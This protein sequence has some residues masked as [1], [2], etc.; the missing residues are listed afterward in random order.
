[1]AE[2]QAEEL[3]DVAAMAKARAHRAEA[4]RSR[5][6]AAMQAERAAADAAWGAQVDA[7][8]PAAKRAET[9]AAA[10][11]AQ[12]A[13]TQVV[14]STAA[15]AQ[16]YHALALS[17]RRGSGSP[18]PLRSLGFGSP[19]SRT[20]PSGPRRQRWLSEDLDAL[21]ALPA[22]PLVAV[23]GRQQQDGA[24]TGRMHVGMRRGI[25]R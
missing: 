14:V 1:M 5:L 23:V 22:R 19:P 9:A 17:Q 25:A 7:A 16:A 12:A 4:D 8:T 15:T 11:A 24:R 21:A 20:P 6:E 2:A 3:R 10:A 13:A 18:M